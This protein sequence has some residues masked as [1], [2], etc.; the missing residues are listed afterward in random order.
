MAVATR[1]AGNEPLTVEKDAGVGQ[2]IMSDVRVVTNSYVLNKVQALKKKLQQCQLEHLSY[3]M[4]PNRNFV[5]KFSPAAY[6]L[7]KLVVV[8]HLYSDTFAKQYFIES[9]INEDECKYQVG[10]LFRVYNKKKDGSKGIYLKFAINFYHTTSSVLVNGNRVDIFESELFEP[11]CKQIQGSCVKLNIVNEQL[12]EAISNIENCN[13]DLINKDLKEIENSNKS[14]TDNGKSQRMK[15]AQNGNGVAQRAIEPLQAMD[16]GPSD[17]AQTQSY[18]YNCPACDKVAGNNTIACEECNEWFHFGCIGVEQSKINEIPNDVPFICIFCNDRSINQ[19]S[20]MQPEENQ[21]NCDQSELNISN[22]TFPNETELHDS[23]E[24]LNETT[25]QKQKDSGLNTNGPA[26]PG[27]KVIFENESV[28]NNTKKN[29]KAR[30][31]NISNKKAS[32]ESNET[33]LAQKYYI[34]SLENKVNHLENLVNVLQKSLDTNLENSNSPR[35]TIMYPGAEPSRASEDVKIQL[36]ENRLQML[37]NQNIFMNNMLIQNQTQA[38]IRDRQLMMSQFYQPVSM[39]PPLPVFSHMGYHQFPYMNHQP[40]S[41]NQQYLHPNYMLR[42][43]YQL[44]PGVQVPGVHQHPVTTVSGHNIGQFGAGVSQH[45]VSG[46]QSTGVSQAGQSMS[47]PQPGRQGETQHSTNTPV[48]APSRNMPHP[49]HSTITGQK[50]DGNK[51]HRREARGNMHSRRQHNHESGNDGR[52]GDC[53]Q[54]NHSSSKDSKSIDNQTRIQQG[55]ST[56]ESSTEKQTFKSN[57]VQENSGNQHDQSQNFLYIPSLKVPPDVE[58]LG[59]VVNSQ[60]TRL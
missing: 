26:A 41:P 56:H 35:S 4:K 25:E 39:S 12:S 24:K 46:G 45:I 7:A 8:E 23:A 43:A 48:A 47:V 29:S 17:T 11:I 10:S 36:L 6:E 22:P 59:L 27:D 19:D 30:K 37:E 44:I 3:E 52:A 51:I 5:M 31:Q 14:H 38:A 21:S 54:V 1:R 58:D 18:I 60:I 28:S 16:L 32:S 13:T 57:H 50:Q 49:P 40:F 55:K 34:S 20:S 2:N 53:V 9:S 42:P 33:L 15:K